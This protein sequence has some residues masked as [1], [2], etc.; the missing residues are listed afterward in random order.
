MN[1]YRLLPTFDRRLEQAAIVDQ[2]FGGG[3]G[4]TLGGAEIIADPAGFRHS[5]CLHRLEQQGALRIRGGWHVGIVPV[6]QDA[7]GEIVDPMKIMA[8]GDHQA[9]GGKQYFQRAFFRFPFPPAAAFTVGTLE[10]GRAHRAVLVDM[11]QQQFY[12]RAMFI[13]P[14][15]GIFPAHRAGI[16]HA[17]A[18]QTVIFDR[19]ETG[20][21]RPVLE[22][23]ALLQQLIQPLLRIAAEPAP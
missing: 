4:A 5:Q 6:R 22:Q 17:V 7:F 19:Q 14:F 9:A 11:L 13:H 10:I 1:I 2:G 23:L 15:G 20:F 8:L 21:M 16:D 18:V 3:F 12:G